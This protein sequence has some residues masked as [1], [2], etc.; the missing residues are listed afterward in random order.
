MKFGVLG[1]GPVG[2]AL[3]NKLVTLGHDVCMGSRE[4]SNEKALAFA[5]AHAPK[6]TNGTFADAAEVGE[7]L[8]NCTNG[9][10]T[11]EV[12]A[13]CGEKNLEGKVLIDIANPLDFTKGFPPSMLTPSTDSLAE[14]IQRAHPKAKVVKA[15]NT[16]NCNLMVDPKRVASGN[17]DTFVCGNDKGAKGQVTE[18]LQSF[19]WKAVI[20][21]GDLSAARGLES[22]LMLWV[23]MFGTFQT[24]D[25]NIKVVR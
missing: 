18:L 24:P 20:D 8:L 25:F 15:L 7:V 10:V 14:Q 13:Q 9:K 22:F 4:S 19:G 12:L 23:R 11:L 6:S 5:R 16:M 21:L 3:A 17:H 1:T 2:Q